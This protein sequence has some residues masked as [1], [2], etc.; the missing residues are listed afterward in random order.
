MTIGIDNLDIAI[1]TG[2]EGT[3]IGTRLAIETLC[4]WITVTPVF[5]HVIDLFAILIETSHISIE[6]L[7]KNPW[8]I[9]IHART[10]D[11]EK[12]HLTDIFVGGLHSIRG[13]L[14]RIDRRGIILDRLIE[15]FIISLCLV[16]NEFP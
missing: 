5:L 7:W 6:L 13:T 1:D 12:W 14:D 8:H 2:L 10:I 4:I 16:L 3:E 15:P 11:P 9:H